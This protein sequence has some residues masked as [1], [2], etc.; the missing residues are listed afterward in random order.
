MQKLSKNKGCLIHLIDYT[1]HFSHSDP[2]LSKISF[3]SYSDRKINFL[4][5]N[6]YMYMNMLR[7]DD[8]IEFFEKNSFKIL[9]QESYIDKNL[10]EKL[11]KDKSKFRL[12]RKYINKNNLVLATDSS[13][14][15]LK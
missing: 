5:K 13:W 10:L 2:N 6:R 11:N 3:L 4:I 14:F 9:S 8:F 1:D 15:V 7:H 12:R